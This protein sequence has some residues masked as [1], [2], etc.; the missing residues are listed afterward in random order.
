MALVVCVRAEVDGRA[1]G[2]EP[3]QRRAPVA[4][5]CVRPAVELGG[6][7]AAVVRES[8]RLERRDR[9]EP[10]C[11]CPR[12]SPARA[13][14]C[15]RAR[16]RGR[17]RAPSPRQAPQ[18]QEY[19]QR[20]RRSR[21]SRRRAATP[22]RP[23]TNVLVQ[24]VG[25]RVR[26]PGPRARRA[27][28]A[29]AR[30]A[31]RAPRTRPRARACAAPRSHAP[32]PE[33]SDGIDESAK[34][35]AAQTTTG[36]HLAASDEPVT[37]ANGRLAPHNR[38]AEREPGASP[39]RSRRC[40]GRRSVATTPLACG[41]GRRRRGEPRVRRPAARRRVEPLAEGGFVLRRS[42]V[43]GRCGRA[44][45]SSR[46]RVASPPASAIR[47]EGKTQTIFAPAPRARSTP[48]T[49][50][51]ALDGA[52][53]AGEFYY[54]VAETSFGP[55]VDQIGR[56]AAA[57]STGW[58]FKVNGA[59]PPVGADKVE[60]Q[61]GD[62]VLWYWAR[63][64][65]L[66]GGP[67]TLDLQAP[68]RRV[69]PGVPAGRHRRAHAPPPAPS[70]AS[71]GAASR[72]AA[73]A[74]LPQ[75]QAR[76][77]ARDARRRRA[78]ERAAGSRDARRVLAGAARALAARRRLR[79]RGRRRGGHGHAL[80]HARS[81]RDGA[82]RGHRA[83]GP[84]RAAGARPRGRRRHAL[85]RPLRP[86]GR[87]ARGLA[88]RRPRLVL[89]RER[90][91]RRP[92]RSRVPAARTARSRG[93]TTGAGAGEPRQLVVVG[94]F[95]EPFVHGYRRHGPAGRRALRRRPRQREALA[96]SRELVGARSVALGGVAVPRGASVVRIVGGPPRQLRRAARA[97]RTGRTR[98]T[99]SA[100]AAARLARAARPLAR[101]RY[102]G[103][104]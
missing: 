9:R 88:R 57:G 31:L 79:R 48:R 32:S 73:G 13:G 85:R 83:G 54:H 84:D 29:R 67:P 77:R 76:A 65:R 5:A 70:S 37:A 7:R 45:R 98:S 1:I 56:Y 74:S 38:R 87:R 40:E 52:S 6:G 11:R 80:D 99:L 8:R 78:L 72:P 50:L 21:R 49:P 92:R 26:D 91:R 63:V 19:A 14:A 59:R 94:A 89:L 33:S 53:L 104:P 42:L 102:E 30:A 36:S 44:P 35:S 24:L 96:R 68:R 15:R 86:G 39:G 69:L 34:M 100:T 51:E 81:R 71:T 16:R 90:R 17:A 27:P 3:F 18:H 66:T 64:R 97:R 41:P 75:G 2:G 28:A 61:D 22:C 4:D 47:V 20:A 62:V 23:G 55:Y 10:A 25:R 103:L 46:R 58:V 82:V 93:G 43:L 101:F 12:A 95:P 60:L